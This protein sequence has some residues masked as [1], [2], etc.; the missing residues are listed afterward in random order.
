[1]LTRSAGLAISTSVLESLHGKL[2]IKRHS[3]S[4][5]YIS[6]RLPMSTN[7][8]EALPGK[9]DIKRHSFSILYISASLQMLTNV[10][11]ALPGKLDIKDANPVQTLTVLTQRLNY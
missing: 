7:V 3:S 8:L 9:L 10:L 1:M 5:I 4:I 6:A 2:D 11:K